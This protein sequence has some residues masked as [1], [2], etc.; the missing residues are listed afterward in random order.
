MRRGGAPL[1]TRRTV[2]G[3]F[4][5]EVAPI[6]DRH[7]GGPSCHGASSP[8]LGLTLSGAQPSVVRGGLVDT[9]SF[10]MPDMSIIESGKPEER[11]LYRKVS[12]NFEGLDGSTAM[13][14]TMPPAG[15]PLSESE[16]E[17]IR[18][19]ITAAATGD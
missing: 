8:T 7:C 18:S 5:T 4:A 1:R 12:G 2:P 16:L 11:W 9:A 3:A 15:M 6:L 17:A 10:E 19:W 13:Y 14:T